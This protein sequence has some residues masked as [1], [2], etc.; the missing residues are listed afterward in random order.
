[1]NRRGFLAALIAAPVAA[2]LPWSAIA[3]VIAPVAPVVAAEIDYAV[4]DLIAARRRAL[5]LAMK[6]AIDAAMYGDGAANQA[7]QMIGFGRGRDG[8]EKD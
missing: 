8:H 6:K 1:M 5:N 3:K 4:I 7:S 2:K